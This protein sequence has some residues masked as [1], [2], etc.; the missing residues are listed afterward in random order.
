MIQKPLHVYLADD[1]KIF[2]QGI[3]RLLSGEPGI[4]VD[5]FSYDG[6]TALSAIRQ[7]QPQLLITDIRMDGLTGIELTRIVKEEFPEMKVI[8]LSMFDKPEIINELIDAGAEGY[9]LKDLEKSEL[10]AAI[11][12]V[13]EGKIYY[14]STIAKTLFK[15]FESRSF[16]TKREREIIVLIAKEKSNAEIAKTLFI[17]EH[18][19]ESHRKNIF[20]KTQT[21]SLVGLINYAH[22]HK[23]I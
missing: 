5:G 18:T 16:L 3:S 17:S 9:L 22:E 8:G 2:V 19:V 13:M 14:S 12:E 10:M 6:S 4:E 7:N 15:N 20:R 21:K 11:E 1:H 23:L